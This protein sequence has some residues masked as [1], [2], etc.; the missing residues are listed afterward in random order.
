MD[1]SILDN[2]FC[3]QKTALENKRRKIE[4]K[5]LSGTLSDSDFERLRDETKAEISSIEE[6]LFELESTQEARVD[7]THEILRFTRDIYRTY[8]TA[9]PTLKRHYLAFFWD[10]FE[11]VD[12]VI[13]NSYPSLVFKE[14]L[15]LEQLYC[16][17]R[18]TK[19]AIDSL[20]NHS[21]I[22]RPSVLLG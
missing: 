21:G 15:Q 18:K 13:L 5:L 19:E 20:G 17:D 3:F 2:D 4:E 1:R 22:L 14:L 6:R 8:R 9:S 16:K 11:V 12:G 10:K 7:I